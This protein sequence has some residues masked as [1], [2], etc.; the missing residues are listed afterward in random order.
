MKIW[1]DF[2]YLQEVVML[3]SEE[4]PDSDGDGIADGLEVLTGT[5]PLNPNEFKIDA[6]DIT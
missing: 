6:L 1:M 2:L 5:D 3:T 4:N